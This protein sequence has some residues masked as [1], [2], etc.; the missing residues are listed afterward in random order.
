MIN[1]DRMSEAEWIQRLVNLRARLERDSDN[2][3]ELSNMM[4]TGSW[5]PLACG[6]EQNQLVEIADLMLR[7]KNMLASVIENHHAE[8]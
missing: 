2:V 5:S 6:D 7:A 8:A 4:E 3:Y 1:R